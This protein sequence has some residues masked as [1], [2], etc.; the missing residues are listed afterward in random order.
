MITNSK[1]TINFIFDTENAALCAVTALK[2]EEAFK[3]RSTSNI[4]HKGKEVTIMI[5]SSDSVSLRASINAYLR[6]VQVFEDLEND[7]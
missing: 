4:I 7:E 2:G 1:A 5:E 3:K 6:D